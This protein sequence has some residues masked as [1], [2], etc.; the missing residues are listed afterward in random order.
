MSVDLARDKYRDLIQQASGGNAYAGDALTEGGAVLA[1]ALFPDDFQYYACGLELVDGGTN[2]V[3][4][5]FMFPVMPNE[6]TFS[7][8]KINSISKTLA[9]VVSYRNNTFNPKQITLEGWFGRRFRL[10][11][12]RKQIPDIGNAGLAGAIGA[13]SQFFPNVKTG[14]G[15]TRILMKIFERANQESLIGYPLVCNFYNNTLNQQY[16]VELKNLSIRQNVSDNMLYNYSLEMTAIAPVNK[17]VVGRILNRVKAGGIGGI[18]QKLTGAVDAII[19]QS[20]V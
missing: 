3:Y 17:G 15:C 19:A 4:E 11:V 8:T 9:G 6:M 12:G 10:M 16:V 7:D 14:Y 20:Q 1:N 5:R 2:K 18:N 13:V